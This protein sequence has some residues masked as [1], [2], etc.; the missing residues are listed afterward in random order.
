[1]SIF[2]NLNKTGLEQSED[3][4][5][6]SFGTVE[7]DYYGALI[8]NAYVTKSDSGAMAM[9]Y[10]FLLDGNKVLRQQIYFTNKKG[11]NWFPNKEDKTKKVPLPGFTTVDD[12]CLCTVGKEL[13]EIEP[14]DKMVNIYN[15]DLKKEVPTNV[16][17]LV[18]LLGQRV[19]LGVLKVLE[20]KNAKD[21]AGNYVPTAETRE[22]N[23][24]DKVF[25]E[26]TGMTTVEARNGVETAAFKDGW[27]ERNK[28]KLRD[29]RK[30][31]DGQAGATGA[32]QA[33]SSSSAPQAG[34]AKPRASLF[35]KKS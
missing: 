29:K 8:K 12:I 13:Y 16:P 10:E 34:D 25:H 33:A 26:E 28:G 15:H 1:M 5:G 2:K 6:G 23:E 11:E 3:R 18:E 22:I 14:E 4:V 30:V 9:N 27:I 17:V 7:T 24:I 19:G 32:P 35:G 20:N 31:K 21:S